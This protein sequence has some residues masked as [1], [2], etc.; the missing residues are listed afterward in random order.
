MHKRVIFFLY[1]T[2]LYSLLR[3][4]LFSSIENFWTKLMCKWVGNGSIVVV[5]RV[6]LF[7]E[8]IQT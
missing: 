7:Q 8:A 2:P 3:L 5:I 4:A 6:S 1:V